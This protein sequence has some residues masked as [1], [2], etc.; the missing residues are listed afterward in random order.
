MF[1]I[2]ELL[3]SQWSSVPHKLPH[4][5][6]P[7]ILPFIA[8]LATFEGLLLWYWVALNLFQVLA[9]GAILAFFTT[10]AGKRALSAVA[11]WR[12]E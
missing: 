2:Y 10:A 6:S 7:K 5:F 9:Y 8:L 4:L 1:M 11:T 12:K 3:S